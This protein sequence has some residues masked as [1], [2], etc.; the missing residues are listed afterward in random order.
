MNFKRLYSFLVLLQ[1]AVFLQAQSLIDLSLQQVGNNRSELEKVITFYT[2]SGDKQK[3]AAAQ[4]F[5][6]NMYGQFFYDGPIMKK[7]NP[8]FQYLDSLNKN[9]IP[10]RDKTTLS[11]NKSIE[12]CW[13]DIQ[14]TIS[15]SDYSTI[16]QRL[17]NTFLSSQ[18]IIKHIDLAFDVWKKNPWSMSYSFNEFCEYILPY[19]AFNE[20]PEAWMEYFSSR[21]KN[22]LSFFAYNSNPVLVADS[23]N[24]EL[25]KWFS[26]GTLLYNYP[27]DMELSR[28]LESHVGTCKH[29]VTASLYAFRSAGIACAID[30]CKQYGNRSQGHTWICV[31]DNNKQMIPV[32]G[33]STE[34]LPMGYVFDE[35]TLN[36]KIPKIFR[37]TFAPQSSSLAYIRTKNDIIPPMFEDVREKDV[38]SEYMPVSDVKIAI[39]KQ[40]AADVKFAY[41]GSTEKL[42]IPCYIRE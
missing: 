39:D 41:L 32:N 7:Y 6:T 34:W 3:L 40:I 35:Q 11:L 5:I 22:T 19:K 15:Q 4:Y 25:E 1:F 24:K 33:A 13:I 12:D 2:Q 20:K 9:N 27:F 18:Q 10:K 29:M 8:F 26:F 23:L 37:K 36:V 30:Y 42:S 31:L 17:D 28:L 16:K 14:K 21:N 38:T